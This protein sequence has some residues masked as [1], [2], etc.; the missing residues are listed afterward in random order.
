VS[1]KSLRVAIIGFVLFIAQLANAQLKPEELDKDYLVKLVLKDSSRFTAYVLA[2]PLPD[3]IIVETR[4]GRLEIPTE[5]ILYAEDYR[6]NNILKD[7][8]RKLATRNAIDFKSQ[9]LTKYLSRQKQPAL[10]LLR[11]KDHDVFRGQR[12]L[13]DDSANVILY[14]PHGNLFFKYPQIDYVENWSRQGDKREEFFTSAYLNAEDL[15]ASQTFIT[16]TAKP[17]GQDHF[18]IASYMVA[19]LQANYGITDWLSFNGGG[20]FAPFLPTQVLTGTAG[21]KITPIQTDLFG[22]AVGAQGVYSEVVKI[23]RIGFPYVVATYGGWDS[24]LSI[25]GGYSFKNEEDS[26]G[27]QYT[28][29]NA[30]LAVAGALRVGENLKLQ[31]ELFFIQDFDIVPAVI[32]MR[33]FDDELTIDAG[34]VFSLFTSGNARDTRTLGEYVFNTEFKLI[35]M[36]SGSYHF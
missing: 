2:R 27:L 18:F 29:E 11:T 15:R 24:H 8:I 20:V 23:T 26:T 17:F 3:R 31:T 4:N 28:A 33:F 21:L 34:L 5:R 22:V 35:P 16:P 13:F 1:Q 30:L 9:Q 19:G 12:Y 25:L 14:T 10:S 36:V 32:S 7:Q 6:F